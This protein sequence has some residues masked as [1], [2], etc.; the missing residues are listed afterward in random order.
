MG[1]SKF[2]SVQDGSQIVASFE[3]FQPSGQ[4]L[5]FLSL[6]II[7]DHFS[8]MWAVIMLLMYI[9]LSANCSQFKTWVTNSKLHFSFY[10][11]TVLPTFALSIWV[12]IVDSWLRA[13]LYRNTR[14]SF[15]SLSLFFSMSAREGAACNY[16][17]NQ[18]IFLPY[19]IQPGFLIS[20]IPPC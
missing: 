17:L 3:R 13:V 2:E 16:F 11:I 6:S 10:P 4:N 14:I 20:K 5:G 19:K 9:F 18:T 7:S 12:Y 15:F 1:I 8:Y